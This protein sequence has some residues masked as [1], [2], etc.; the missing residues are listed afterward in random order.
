MT[1]GPW[2]CKNCVSNVRLWN[3]AIG[4]LGSLSWVQVRRLV[5]RSRLKTEVGS[6]VPIKGCGFLNSPGDVHAAGPLAV[7]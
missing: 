6:D 7:R 2:P 3:V 5:D 4:G 1:L